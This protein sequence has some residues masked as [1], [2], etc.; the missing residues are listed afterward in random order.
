MNIKIINTEAI[1]TFTVTVTSLDF[2][3]ELDFKY[4]AMNYFDVLKHVL[5][6]IEK[7]EKIPPIQ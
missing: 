1:N 2:S 6:F 7:L 4:N 5:D 3:F